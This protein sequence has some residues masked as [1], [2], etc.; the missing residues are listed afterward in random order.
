[1]LCISRGKEEQIN[2]YLETAAGPRLLGSI[3]HLGSCSNRQIRLGFE[4]SLDVLIARD[5]VDVIKQELTRQLPATRTSNPPGSQE[6]SAPVAGGE[7][8]EGEAA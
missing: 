7:R 8:E 1:M 4:M 2:L 5:E 6:G 3:K